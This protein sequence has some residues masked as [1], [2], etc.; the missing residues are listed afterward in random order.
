MTRE[1]SRPDYG[2]KQFGH[3]F[4]PPHIHLDKNNK[5]CVSIIIRECESKRSRMGKFTTLEAKDDPVW[6]R[7]LSSRKSRGEKEA[8]KLV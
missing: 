5:D 3:F 7:G 4:F 6:T 8:W 1:G 2:R